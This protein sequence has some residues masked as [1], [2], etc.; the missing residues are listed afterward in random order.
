MNARILLAGSLLLNCVCVGLLLRPQ[1]QQ[2]DPA[3]SPAPDR[4][5]ESSHPFRWI[6]LESPDYPTFIE[7][8]RKIGCPERTV[9]EIIMADLDDLYAP[10]RQSVVDGLA[11]HSSTREQTNAA[12]QLSQLRAE[13]VAVFGQLFGLRTGME[14]RPAQN[15][16]VRKP[17]EQVPDNTASIPLVFQAIDTNRVSLSVD[18]LEM[19][20]R[21]QDS[22]VSGLGTNLDVNSPEYLRRW[23]AA[24]L[25]ADNLLQAL[26]G[27]QLA[28]QYEAAIAPGATQTP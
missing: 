16:P 26:L 17:R 8:L 12:V 11:G 10:R 15:Q 3:S 19:I 23:Q 25:Q 24:R 27:R 1:Q 4:L 22:F 28:L 14:N 20:R 7:N 2:P 9:R 6:Q 5:S 21:V 18:D 13:E